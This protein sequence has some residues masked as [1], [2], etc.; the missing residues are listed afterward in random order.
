[1][2]KL[3][4]VESAAIVSSLWTLECT[5]PAARARVLGP[6]PAVAGLM[7]T[8]AAADHSWMVRGRVNISSLN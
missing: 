5:T 7:R 3:P 6:C 1:M 4:A 2:D 8:L